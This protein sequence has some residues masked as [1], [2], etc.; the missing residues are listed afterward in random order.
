MILCSIE[1]ASKKRGNCN[2]K[3]LGAES[4]QSGSHM[5]TIIQN[6]TLVGLTSTITTYR[7][8]LP[9]GALGLLLDLRTQPLLILHTWPLIVNAIELAGYLC[10]M[11]RSGIICKSSTCWDMRLDHPWTSLSGKEQ[12]VGWT[13]PDLFFCVVI[14]LVI[15]IG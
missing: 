11:F 4:S 7:V 6:F 15:S 3:T 1:L 14:S 8:W 12:L 2:N 10:R 13:Q 9:F 5:T